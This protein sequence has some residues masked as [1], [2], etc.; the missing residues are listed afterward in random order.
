ME[1]GENLCLSTTN[2][3][4]RKCIGITLGLG[5]MFAAFISILLMKFCKNY[6]EQMSAEA[7]RSV[8]EW[9]YVILFLLPIIGVS[10]CE[11]ILQFC[12]RR[13]IV[14]MRTPFVHDQTQF[15]VLGLY[16]SKFLMNG[17]I[18]FLS[19]WNVVDTLPFGYLLETY[20]PIFRFADNLFSEFN[21]EW[22]INVGASLF[23][24]QITTIFSSAAPE[25]VLYIMKRFAQWKD[26]EFTDDRRKTK[27]ILQVDY[28]D[29][30]TG[31][32]FNYALGYTQTLVS[33]TLGITF[34]GGMPLLY[35][36]MTFCFFFYF[37]LHKILRKSFSKHFF[38]IFLEILG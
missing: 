28:E 10:V 22:Y 38:I 24:M 30:Y 36:V 23:V 17:M 16:L 5:L 25:I 4:A 27:Q 35:L 2:L 29:M 19:S 8:T 33:F 13:F 37:W 31:E 32:Q 12:L 26:R 7:N 9:P 18:L 20:I 1:T 11:A 15:V 34:S 6:M 14:F 21:M 3:R